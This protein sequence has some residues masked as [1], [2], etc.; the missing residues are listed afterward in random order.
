MGIGNKVA[1]WQRGEYE[2]ESKESSNF[3]ASS[4]PPMVGRRDGETERW[5][6]CEGRSGVQEMQDAIGLNGRRV[7]ATA[8]GTGRVLSRSG[9]SIQNVVAVGHPEGRESWKSLPRPPS[10]RYGY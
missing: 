7:R 6:S 10:G 5:V 4:P 9:G 2:H 3:L 8:T 1:E